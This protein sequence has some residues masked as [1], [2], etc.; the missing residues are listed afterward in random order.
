MRHNPKRETMT[1]D[2]PGLPKDA[3]VERFQPTSGRFAGVVGLVTAGI[4][5]TSRSSRSTPVRRSAW[6]SWPASAPCSSWVA[7]LRPACG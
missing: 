2:Q 5:L 1:T 4:V 7:L 3:V 6:R